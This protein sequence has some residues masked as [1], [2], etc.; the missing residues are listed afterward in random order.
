M[1]YFD[2]TNL[3]SLRQ[4]QSRRMRS[5][6][7]CCSSDWRSE[8]RRAASVFKAFWAPPPPPIIGNDR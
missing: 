8:S 2:E 7:W 6:S 5:Q 3:R 4:S 1:R